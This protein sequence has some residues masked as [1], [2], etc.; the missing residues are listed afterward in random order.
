MDAF[1]VINHPAFRGCARFT[2]I[3][4]AIDAA[5]E[6]DAPAVVRVYPGTYPEDVTLRPGVAVAGVFAGARVGWGTESSP[7]HGS[8][9]LPTSR[10]IVEGGV[11]LAG[12]PGHYH[13]EGLSVTPSS[14]P[15][16]EAFVPHPG[17]PSEATSFLT[18][19]ACDTAGS[20]D[21]VPVVAVRG[22]VGAHLV[23]TTVYGAPGVTT[24]L[25][26]HESPDLV[27]MERCTV[28]SAS[29]PALH[30]G[31]IS[32]AWLV[33]CE[34]GGGIRLEGPALKGRGGTIHSGAPLFVVSGTGGHIE[35]RWSHLRVVGDER[36]EHIAVADPPTTGGSIDLAGSI[37]GGFPPAGPGIRVTAAPLQ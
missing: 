36:T 29:A 5:A 37:T 24:A 12:D 25:V 1:S 18:V 6:W 20:P 19:R 26:Q 28:S 3:Q 32:E 13:L 17:F 7:A 34:L 14:G 33:D 8:G 31:I 15:A 27:L 9:L 16:L 4:R 11:H 30:V 2:S 22:P 35:W 21:E 23:E 10:P